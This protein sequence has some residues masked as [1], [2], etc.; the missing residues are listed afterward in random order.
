M[1]NDDVSTHKI[2]E[3]FEILGATLYQMAPSKI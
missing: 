3:Q 1:Q 2:C